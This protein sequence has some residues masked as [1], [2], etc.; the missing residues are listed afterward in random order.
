MKCVMRV[1]GFV[2]DS[3]YS[4][5]HNV[6]TLHERWDLVQ[7]KFIYKLISLYVI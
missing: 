1:G 4:D 2:K 7:N 6:E 5:W 3:T